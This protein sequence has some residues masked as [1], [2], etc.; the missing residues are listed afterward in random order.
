M[1][2]DAA[3]T[4]QEN[5]APLVPMQKVLRGRGLLVFLVMLSAFVAMSTDMY[6]P[7][8]PSM[9]EYFGVPEILTNLTIILFFIFFSAA[10]LVWGPLSDKNGR[11]PI[12]LV[13]LVGYTA[14]S[15]LC[16]VS[17]NIYMLIVCRVLQAIGAGAASSTATAIIRDVYT[18][19]TLEKSIATVQ[20]M[21]VVVPVAA[22][23]LGAL[24]LRITDWRGC[25]FVQ[26]ALG[27]IV[28]IMTLLYTETLR[29]KAGFGV[30]QTLGR[31]FV[32]L[33]NMRFTVLLLIFSSASICFLA[34]VSA[35]AFIYQD[36]FG[37]SEQ[38]Y[39]YFF[40]LNAAIM[41]FG[42]FLYIRLSSRFSR[43][44]LITVNFAIMFVAG[45]LICTVGRLSPWAFALS[46]LPSTMMGSF[47]GPPSR[48]LMLSQQTRDTAL[49]RTHQR[50]G[51]H[52]GQR[53]HDRHIAEFWQSRCRD[54]RDQY[55]P[56]SFVRLRVAVFHRPAVSERRKVTSIS[57]KRGRAGDGGLSFTPIPVCTESTRLL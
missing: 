15:L 17:P 5:E 42:P 24:L 23:M 26:T 33:K 52:H 31:L 9:T 2:Q 57:E 37:L 48:F 40:A 4:A 35:S 45:L 55:P 34:F 32:V 53:R 30:L 56:G 28:V 54:R 36:Y 13:G 11:R 38:T 20:S 41:V 1:N 14:A 47:I 29:E 18:G 10:A 50:R 46:L 44:T 25:F 7:A 3:K 22:P 12:L 6:L 16:A 27:A 49:P 21:V 39:S 8:L 43:F 51:G 19:R